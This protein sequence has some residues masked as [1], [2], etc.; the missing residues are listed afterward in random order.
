MLDNKGR[1][2]QWIGTCTDIEDQKRAEQ[3]LVA[4]KISGLKYGS[5]AGTEALCVISEELRT[6]KT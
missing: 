3:D 6:P 2:I 5:A 4:E 1:I